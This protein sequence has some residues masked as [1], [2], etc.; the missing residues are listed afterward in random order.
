MKVVIDIPVG[1]LD[2]LRN[3]VEA[4][5]FASLGQFATLALENQ[6]SLEAPAHGSRT[7]AVTSPAP[8]RVPPQVEHLPQATGAGFSALRVASPVSPSTF[9]CSAAAHLS[10][11]DQGWI[12]GIINRIF[13][14]KVALRSLLIDSAQGPAVLL[15]AKSRAGE[16]AESVGKWI[17][18][19]Y[20]G[21]GPPRDESLLTG[22]PTREPLYRA[23]ERFEDHFF[24]RVDKTGRPWG[25]LFELGMAGVKTAEGHRLVALTTAGATLAVL[26]NP[27]LDEA[28]LDRA[29]SEEEIGAYLDMVAAKVPRERSCLLAILEGLLERDMTVA[30][31]DGLA[32]RVLPKR[33]SDAA[34]QTMKAGALGRMQDLE[35]ITRV[36]TGRSARFAITQTGESA[37]NKLAGVEAAPTGVSTTPDNHRTGE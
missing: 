6:L 9:E 5:G 23:R 25:A 27:V 13:P 31:M 1:L 7:G 28:R 19:M 4:G 35:L 33:L 29:L 18:Q 20:A 32:R 17:Q 21:N 8:P 11:E 30:Q 26:P 37:L 24:G 2:R 10:V 14:I 3:A 12:W 36:K 15:S 22:L 16:R 34:A